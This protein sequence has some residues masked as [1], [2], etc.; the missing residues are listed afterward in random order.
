MKEQIL[1]YYE[2]IQEIPVRFMVNDERVFSY[3]SHTSLHSFVTD[4]AYG[5]VVERKCIDISGGEEVFAEAFA[6]DENRRYCL[7][8]IA[9][10]PEWRKYVNSLK[11]TVNGITVWDS[12][13]TFFEQVNLGWPSQYIAVPK[14]ILKR[15]KNHIAV[16]C[17]NCSG[18]GLY[19]SELKLISFP[20]IEDKHQISVINYAKVG[21]IFAVAVADYSRS[22][23]SVE[24]LENCALTERAYYGDFCVLTF[25]ATAAGQTRAIAH[26]ADNS[27][28]LYM[29]KAIE[30]EDYFLFGTDGDDHRHDDSWENRFIIESVVMSGMGNFIQFRPR[31]L[32]NYYKIMPDGEY[33]KLFGLMHAF[34]LKYG[35][36]GNGRDME[37]LVQKH[38]ENFL[39]YHIHEPYWYFCAAQLYGDLCEQFYGTDGSELQRVSTFAEAKSIYINI[40][41][42][43]QKK[44]AKNIGMNSS[45][46]PSFLCLYED[47]AGFERITIEPVSNINMLTGAVRTTNVKMWG[48]HIPTDWYFGVPVDEVKSNKYRLALQYLYLN[49]ASYLYAEN[50]LYK[51]NAF[52]RCDLESAHCKR[53]RRYQREFY[54]Y[55]V[56]HPRRGRLLVDKAFVYGRNEFIMWKVNDRMAELKEK[57]WDSNVWGKWDNAYQVAWNAVEV[58][59]PCSAYQNAYVSPLNKRLFSGT[60]Y[61]NVDIVNAEK[62]FSAYKTLAFLGWNTMNDELLERLKSFVYLGGTLVVSYAQMNYTDNWTEEKTFPDSS[63]IAAFIGLEIQRVEELAPKVEFNDGTALR[64][65]ERK[66]A[67]CG[68]ALTAERICQDENGRG[69]VYQNRFGAGEVYFIALKD[70]VEKEEDISVLKKVLEIVGEKS[71]WRCDNNNVSFTVREECGRYYVNVLNMNCIEDKSERFTIRFRGHVISDEIGV[72][73]IKEFEL[74]EE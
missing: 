39:G 17:A 56:S 45:G 4:W 28:K 62:E 59:L 31:H 72:G 8:I 15:G 21:G 22:F 50:A 73:E 41:Q 18:G 34:G 61:G 46:A 53:N 20:E 11:I 55:V 64:F 69:V 19:L 35:L 67:A 14:G 54:D 58:W 37:N 23:S 16:C 38:Q 44:Y 30:N 26:F 7:K 48:A 42:D 24:N 70:Y 68:N 33:E 10:M 5:K 49:G 9:C 29:P 13:E 27:L 32:R 74:A 25:R 51:T 2:D 43:M 40:L 47:A 52:D 3:A 36:C 1:R 57:D 65:T 60:P 63:K 12:D 66:A 71:E 6:D